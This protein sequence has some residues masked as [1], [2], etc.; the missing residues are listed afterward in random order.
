[1]YAD[2]YIE[3]DQALYARDH[4]ADNGLTGQAFT[5]EMRRLNAEV[6]RLNK[7]LGEREPQKQVDVLADTVEDQM[8]RGESDVDLSVLLP[9]NYKL[10]K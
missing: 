8:A 10:P 7:A 6:D 3:R 9:K 2:L 4:A 5:A 1:M